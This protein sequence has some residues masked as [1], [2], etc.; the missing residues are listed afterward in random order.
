IRHA[1]FNL[2]EVPAHFYQIWIYPDTSGL[3]PSYDQ[4]SFAGT[5]WT[6]RLVPVA[7]GQRLPNVVAFHTDAT[8]YLGSLEAHRRLTHHTKGTR[9]VFVYLTDGEL[10]LDG[11]RLSAKDQARIDAETPLT[12]TAHQ[13]T[14]FVLID[15]P[16]CRGGR[17]DQTTLQ[18]ARG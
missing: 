10:T 15:V 14:R 2:G 7:S 8:L 6:N 1:E 3:P 17:Y 9:R 4:K 5:V 13:D 12:L 18:G 11:A 16:S